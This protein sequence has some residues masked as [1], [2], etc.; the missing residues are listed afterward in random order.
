MPGG[1]FG[2]PPLR[3][4]SA[5]GNFQRNGVPVRVASRCLGELRQR[6]ALEGSLLPLASIEAF[7]SDGLGVADPEC[8]I[9]LAPIRHAL[10]QILRGSP[11]HRF[12]L[13]ETSELLLRVVVLAERRPAALLAILRSAS[14]AL[15]ATGSAWLARRCRLADEA[16]TRFTGGGNFPRVARAHPGLFSVGV[17]DGLDLLGAAVLHSLASGL[18]V[19][20]C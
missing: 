12:E 20:V 7:G 8:G 10:E 6:R 9:Q 1:K 14:G 16:W 15:G 19:R 13:G 3:R 5:C 11:V 4:G 18:C 17:S 2:P